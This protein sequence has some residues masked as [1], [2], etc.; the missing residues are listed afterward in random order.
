[1]GKEATPEQ[2]QDL[3]AKAAA[4]G[5]A[6]CALQ[7]GES[8]ELAT[9]R[10]CTDIF[11]WIV[12]MLFWVVMFGIAA[13]G[14]MQGEPQLLTSG[15]DFNGNIC[16]MKNTPYEER[17]LVYY[18]YPYPENA[19]SGTMD[20]VDLTWALCV[21][22]CPDQLNG[23]GQVPVS[24]PNMCYMPFQ[25]KSDYSDARIIKCGYEE[26]GRT[27]MRQFGIE[28]FYGYLKYCM[29][30]M[31]R[32]KCSD[33]DVLT[34]GLTGDSAIKLNGWKDSKAECCSPDKISGVNNVVGTQT[35]Y[36]RYSDE[37]TMGKGAPDV[38]D[39]N[40]TTR[41]ELRQ[42]NI[43][44]GH[45]YGFCF[46]PYPSYLPGEG[47]SKWTRC[48]PKFNSNDNPNSTAAFQEML[49]T[50]AA[51]MVKDDASF[52]AQPVNA[53]SLENGFK[54]VIAAM[55]GPRATLTYMI[56]ELRKYRWVI[57]GCVAI[58]L[59]T[60]IVF[61]FLLKL[62]AGPI[63]YG[64]MF[65]VL[66]GS[67]GMTTL[68]GFKA[69]F[70]SPDRLP[71]SVSGYAS[72][73]M[74]EGVTLG[75]AQ[76][77]ME[78]VIASAVLSAIFTVVYMVVFCVMLPRVSLAINI[79][80]VASTCL[81]SMPTTLLFPVV[82]WVA[83]VILLCYFLIVLWYLASAGTFDPDLHRYVWND[84]LQNLMLVHLFG[85][86]WGRAWILAIGQIVIA[87]A[88]ADWFL[89]PDKSSA[90]IGLPA[91]TSFKRTMRYHM[92]TAA[93]GS[94][95]IAVVQMIRLAFRYYMWQL[96]R[97]GDKDKNAIVK[98]LWSIGECCLACLERFLNF[99]NKN[100]YIQCAIKGSNFVTG[101]KDAC[102]LLLRNCL[103]VGTIN[104]ITTIFCFIG[105]FFISIS[106]ALIGA[107]WI[108]SVDSGGLGA[109]MS[110]VSSAPMFPVIVI[111]VISY[112]IACAFLD[113][114]DMCIDTIF[115]CHC[116]DE[117]Y[118]AQTADYKKK[119]PGDMQKV[120]DSKPPP[121]DKEVKALS[122]VVVP[123]K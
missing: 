103:R 119:T 112:G 111:L 72:T 71:T 22:K 1:M 57:A 106:T 19:M 81:A 100:A 70:V 35:W 87:G 110:S 113:V 80:N 102:M 9:D 115:Q 116:M 3:N 83:S 43:P 15:Y 37:Q 12:F 101:A 77:N 123:G 5:G 20:G 75:P 49:A 73:Q 18:P 42:F 11:C 86:L 13:F 31:P 24:P 74:P 95:I 65:G 47:N 76:T 59:F 56:E 88:C 79:M 14:I 30:K 6:P 21:D 26:G 99:I 52:V 69:G 40:S 50:A 17:P 108:V 109:G 96:T 63:I 29:K 105:K 97:L 45:R 114:W 64:L 16:G 91:L 48:V 2:V 78:L 82:Q 122:A 25:V 33:D 44:F 118:S 93:V 41:P 60:S 98:V 51:D 120:M 84:D 62:L 121:S 34:T 94:F 68:L 61:T 58:A 27:D 66:I 46:V 32:C 54:A 8:F 38:M 92:G 36:D 28:G 89:A 107:L 10:Q 90:A 67:M 55:S 53:T 117:E 4:K 7:P 85:M 39:F 104:I 23:N